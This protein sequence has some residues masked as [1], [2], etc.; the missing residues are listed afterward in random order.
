M[1]FSLSPRENYLL[2]LNHQPTEYT[3]A[4]VTD[5]FGVGRSLPF[6]RGPG[7]SGIDG[8]GVNWVAPWSAVA[9]AL[10]EPGVFMLTDVTEWKK[11]VNMPDLSIYDWEGTSAA[12]LNG[13]DRSSKVFEV[14]SMNSIYERMATLMGFE[15]TLI[16]LVEEPEASYELLSA[17]ADWKIEVM[18]YFAKYYQPDTFIFFDDVAT[19]H[20]LFMSPAT[21]K[22]I[23]K[24]LHTRMCQAAR[25]LGIIPIQH[26]CG[27]ADSLVQDMIDEGCAAWHAVQATNEIESVIETYGDIFTIMGGFNS[28][29]PP[30]QQSATEEMVRAEVNRCIS[31]YG[32]YGK[33]YIFGGNIVNP[34]DPSDPTNT[35]INNTY[36]LDEFIKIRKLQEE[37]SWEYGLSHA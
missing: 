9:A 4:S 22:A 6:E 29:G 33:G 19:E 18:K 3:P 26:T 8:F 32:K 25:E 2:A 1:A 21:Y 31:S 12:E 36:I 14:A 16:A 23:I 10:P 30:G 5:S 28:N 34:I 27:K 11:V 15:E 20:R 13:V 37:G 24:P 35:G 7:G 17:L